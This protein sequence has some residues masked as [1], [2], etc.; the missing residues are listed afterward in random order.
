MT[1][2]GR[3]ADDLATLRALASTLATRARD[4]ARRDGW[5]G[6]GDA[7][8]DYLLLVP[9]FDRLTATAVAAGVGFFGDLRPAPEAEFPPQLERAVAD[10][11]ARGGW[12]LAY[13]NA[14]FREPAAD[15]APRYGNLVVVT[16]RAATDALVRDAHHAEAVRLAPGAYRAIR[17]HRLA[18]S[19]LAAARPSLRLDET[20]VLDFATSPRSRSLVPAVSDEPA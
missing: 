1:V 3:T 13:L 20:L 7:S 2:D 17:I 5:A 19:G 12:L 8:A 4:P 9:S 11:A 6:F 10:A 15:G 16:S 14:R 18:V